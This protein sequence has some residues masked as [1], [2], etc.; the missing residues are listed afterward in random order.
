MIMTMIIMIITL[1]LNSFL[2]KIKTFFFSKSNLKHKGGDFKNGPLHSHFMFVNSKP[3]PY[4]S[5][6]CITYYMILK[7][8]NI[9]TFRGAK[10]GGVGGVSTPPE[11]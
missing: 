2:T 4:K 5:K 3:L 11:F 6:K 7:Y 8:Q 10:Q 1:C 9:T